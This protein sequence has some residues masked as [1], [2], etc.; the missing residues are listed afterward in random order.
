MSNS[1]LEQIL[2]VDAKGKPN[3]VMGVPADY[4]PAL[5]PVSPIPANG[6]NASDPNFA[7]FDT[8]NVFITLKNGQPGEN[9]G[10]YQSAPV[11][12]PNGSEWRKPMVP[13]RVSLQVR[14]LYGKGRVAV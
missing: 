5:L 6:G 1:F 14:K 8:N 7:N 9:G 11:A 10:R 4:K 12:E 3:G 2:T 13:G